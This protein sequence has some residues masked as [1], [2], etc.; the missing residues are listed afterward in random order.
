MNKTSLA[1]EFVH[2]SGITAIARAASIA[3]D[4]HLGRKGN[5][6][7]GA[8]IIHDV[9]PVSNSRGGAFGPAGATVLRDVLVLVPGQIVLTIL[10]SPVNGGGKILFLV[11]LPR[12]R[13]LFQFTVSEDSFSSAASFDDCLLRFEEVNGLIKL[14]LRELVNSGIIVWVVLLSLGGLMPNLISPRILWCGESTVALNVDVVDT[15]ADT[16]EAL[17]TPVSAPRVAHKP[18]LLAVFLAVTYDRDIV[19]DFHITGVIT[20]DTA[21]VVIK[22]LRHGNT[23]SDRTTLVDLLHHVLLT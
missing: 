19:N 9:E 7:S 12:V 6:G 16:E 1:R 14:G 18:I 4:N 21:G 2:L 15:T 3:V 11:K 23:A 20:I 22:S 5:R 13:S 17:L 8:Q 10:I